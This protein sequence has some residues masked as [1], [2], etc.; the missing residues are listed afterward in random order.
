MKKQPWTL[1][2][3]TVGI[4][5]VAA[6]VIYVLR[7]SSELAGPSSPPSAD[8]TVENGEDFFERLDA[9]EADLLTHGKNVP[10]VSRDGRT[11]KVSLSHGSPIE[12]K[13]CLDCGPE[14]DVEH[15]LVDRFTDP[16]AV[17]IYRQFYESDDYVLVLADGGRIDIPSYPVF[18]P[19]KK[20][21]VVVS[22]AE[23]FNWNGLELWDKDNGNRYTR[24]L[25]FEPKGNDMY[26]FLAW[27]GNDKV[28]LEATRNDND[29]DQTVCQGAVLEFQ[30]NSWVVH[31]VPGT[32][33]EN[34]CPAA[35]EWIPEA[36]RRFGKEPRNADQD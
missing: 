27:D 15:Y 2:F 4:A 1:F 11:L 7:A 3:F 6:F 33:R 16:A 23:A 13:D 19:D 21:F 9:R 8:D 34:A 32:L 17:L 5:V 28:K 24:R 35:E 25:H 10:E 29:S 12:F 14:K 26:R 22:A 18:S 20:K 30:H 31:D 36:L